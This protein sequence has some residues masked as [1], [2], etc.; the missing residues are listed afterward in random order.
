MAKAPTMTTKAGRMVVP[1]GTNVTEILLTA[2]RGLSSVTELSPT[3]MVR[4]KVI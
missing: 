4:R 2:L 3:V 1:S